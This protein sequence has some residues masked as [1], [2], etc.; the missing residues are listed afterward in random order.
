MNLIKYRVDMNDIYQSRASVHNWK[1]PIYVRIGI[2]NRFIYPA[3]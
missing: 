3:S 1:T 2:N